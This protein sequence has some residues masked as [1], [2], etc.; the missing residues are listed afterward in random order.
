MS[1]MSCGARRATAHVVEPRPDPDGEIVFGSRVTVR[2]DG[3]IETI[4]IVGE[5]EADPAAGKIVGSREIAVLA[6][7]P[8]AGAGR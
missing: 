3:K 1:R 5:D 4:E 7:E 6:V 2:R 8:A